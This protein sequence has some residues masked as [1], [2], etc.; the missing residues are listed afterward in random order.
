M[1]R[2]QPKK[3]VCSC[4][5]VFLTMGGMCMSCKQKAQ[6]GR[7]SD[8]PD[9]LIT[10]G[11]PRLLKEAT[12]E[13]NEYI[14]LRDHGCACWSCGK[15]YEKDFQ[16]GHIF[17]AGQHSAVRFDEGNIFLQCLNCNYYKTDET[18]LK[19]AAIKFLGRFQYELLEARAKI[20]TR[21]KWDRFELSEIITT[22]REK[23]KN[24]KR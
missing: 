12:G 21:H 2:Y 6:S 4:G 20:D 18:E 13:C 14:R 15:K 7:G 10:F 3:K 8:S 24:I 19:E 5:K 11:I 23:S 17:P 16:A 9:R 22:Y 1:I